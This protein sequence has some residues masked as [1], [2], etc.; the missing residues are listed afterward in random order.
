M[1]ITRGE[2]RSASA[3]MAADKVTT[4]SH[5]S[6][7]P[8][9]ISD[10]CLLGSVK[11]L[12]LQERVGTGGCP[13][14]T[15]SKMPGKCSQSPSA[16]RDAAAGMSVTSSSSLCARTAASTCVRVAYASPQ[17]SMRC[18]DRSKAPIWST[19]AISRRGRGRPVCQLGHCTLCILS[20][21][22]RRALARFWFSLV[23]TTK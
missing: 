15:A 21:Q 2:F 18:E 8:R 16:I 4:L 17:P 3:N 23:V 22:V 11:N 14:R 12:C 5:F 6:H 10:G 7:V 9:W 20:V 19:D 1:H 13:D